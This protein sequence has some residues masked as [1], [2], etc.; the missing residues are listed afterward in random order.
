MNFK[1][2]EVL[3]VNS[4]LTRD[5][6]NVDISNKYEN[7]IYQITNAERKKNQF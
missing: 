2:A 7:L 4:E 6:E 3:K 5:V 1:S